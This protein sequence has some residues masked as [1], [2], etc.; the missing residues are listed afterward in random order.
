MPVGKEQPLTATIT[1]FLTT[2]MGAINNETECV[3]ERLGATKKALLTSPQAVS[4]N[5][6]DSISPAEVNKSPVS[7]TNPCVYQGNLEITSNEAV[8]LHFDT[9]CSPPPQMAKSCSQKPPIAHKKL[10]SGKDNKGRTLQ[11]E[12]VK[13]ATGTFLTRPVLKYFGEYHE[14]GFESVNVYS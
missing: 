1:S 5:A 3:E 10:T 13:Q 12:S 2:A 11:K 4:V 6:R 8:G 7:A 14:N 9:L